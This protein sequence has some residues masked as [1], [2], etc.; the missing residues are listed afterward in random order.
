MPEHHARLACGRGAVRGAWI[1]GWQGGCGGRP[2]AG[3]HVESTRD[4]RMRGHPRTFARRQG[5]I[6]PISRTGISVCIPGLSQHDRGTAVLSGED[7]I[8]GGCEMP[9]LIVCSRALC[10]K[11]SLPLVS[12]LGGSKIQGPVPSSP[13]DPA[14]QH[15]PDG[16]LVTVVQIPAERADERPQARGSSQIDSWHLP[17]A[18]RET[19]DW[20]KTVGAPI[21]RLLGGH[22][23]AIPLFSGGDIRRGAQPT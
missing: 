1:P 10:P 7:D 13:A 17:L 22:P 9:W 11:P 21:V 16:L 18:H 4:R 2:E 20:T 8:P 15:H 3:G 6:F 23:R 5:V 19:G 12:P 14:P